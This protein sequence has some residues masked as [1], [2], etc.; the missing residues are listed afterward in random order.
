MRRG[1]SSIRRGVRGRRRAGRSRCRNPRG[2]RGSTPAVQTRRRTAQR[3]TWQG[4]RSVAERR[5]TP[6]LA[7]RRASGAAWAR[8]ASALAA[9]AGRRTGPGRRT[10]HRPPCL[11]GAAEA[12]ASERSGPGRRRVALRARGGRDA[13]RVLCRGGDAQ[14]RGC[15]SRRGCIAVWRVGGG[16]QERC[17]AQAWRGSADKR[18]GG[19]KRAWRAPAACFAC[20]SPPATAALRK[21]RRT[22]AG[23]FSAAQRSARTGACKSGR[24]KKTAKN[25]RAALRACSRVRTQGCLACRAPPPAPVA[26]RRAPS[27]QHGSGRPRGVGWRRRRPRR[28]RRV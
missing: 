23:C 3:S 18:S 9:L 1:S 12:S 19:G 13:A 6:K 26:A 22:A 27:R 2:K 20:E 10:N 15:A 25:S 8:A 21:P 5:G 4:R 16:T 17:A 28:P 14:M 24:H 7:H 11:R